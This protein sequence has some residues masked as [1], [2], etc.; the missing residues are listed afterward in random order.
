MNIRRS[1]EGKQFANPGD[2]VEELREFARGMQSHVSDRKE[3]FDKIVNHWNR[4]DDYPDLEDKLASVREDKE[5]DY[6]VCVD[7]HDSGEMTS[8]K[9]ELATTD[10]DHLANETRRD[11]IL[12]HTSIDTVEAVAFTS[13]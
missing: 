6:W 12:E 5:E 11:L 2:V 9:T 13:S 4:E 3:E 7:A 1:Y 10:I 8:G